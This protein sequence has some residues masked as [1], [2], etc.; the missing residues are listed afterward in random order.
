[1]GWWWRPVWPGARR[2]GS[3]RA[4]TGAFG[5]ARA[6]GKGLGY[7]GTRRKAV[8]PF[9][10]M[11]G[12]WPIG[13]W[14]F[15]RGPVRQGCP[16]L[17]HRAGGGST[18]VDRLRRLE[19]TRSPKGGLRGN[20]EKIMDLLCTPGPGISSGDDPLRVNSRIR[21]KLFFRIN[22]IDD[23]LVSDADKPGILL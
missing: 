6:R 23:H 9:L 17:R 19:L 10:L 3:G 8:F 1:V 18:Y 12:G 20:T 21:S 16:G 13:G 11:P 4:L 22:P 7:S 14:R 15:S 5:Q 2:T